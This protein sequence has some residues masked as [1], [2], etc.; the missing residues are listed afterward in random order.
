LLAVVVILIEQVCIQTPE[1]SDCLLHLS[2]P[3]FVVAVAAVA[4]V[5]AAV[6]TVAVATVVH[7]IHDYSDFWIY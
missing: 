2:Y 4:T 1:M 7:S 3:C 5:A 6:A